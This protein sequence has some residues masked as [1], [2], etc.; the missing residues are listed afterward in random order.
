MGWINTEWDFPYE[1]H[2]RPFPLRAANV[3]I[4]YL[5]LR[6]LGLPSMQ[7]PDAWETFFAEILQVASGGIY[8]DAKIYRIQQCYEKLAWW[9]T[10][11]DESL[12]IVKQGDWLQVIDLTLTQEDYEALAGCVGRPS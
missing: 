1:V 5:F 3:E 6:R 4:S 10:I 9:L 7:T 8:R 2:E 12:P 11:L